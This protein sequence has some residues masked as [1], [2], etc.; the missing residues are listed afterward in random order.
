MKQ[1]NN[2]QLILLGDGAVGKTS[3][4]MQYK[5]KQFKNE[6]LATLGL[7]FVTKKL[8]KDSKE[9][10]IKIWDTAGQDRFRTMT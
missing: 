1:K 7:D 8:E 5:N 3:I 6:H 10:N 4:I 2:I 9:Y